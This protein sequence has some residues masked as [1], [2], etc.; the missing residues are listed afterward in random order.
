LDEQIATIDHRK[1]TETELFAAFY[2]E[3]TGESLS[4]GQ[5]KAFAAVADR[6]RQ[7]EREATG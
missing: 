7:A 2:R 6:M 5:R 3:V 1:M 4:A